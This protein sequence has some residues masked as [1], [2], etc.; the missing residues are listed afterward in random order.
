MQS[1][2]ELTQPRP[3]GGE[4]RCT[5]ADRRTVKVRR[6]IERSARGAEGGA[7]AGGEKLDRYSEEG[8][9]SWAVFTLQVLKPNSDLLPFF[10]YP[11]LTSALKSDR[12]LISLCTPAKTM[13]TTEAACTSR[14][15]LATNPEKINISWCQTMEVN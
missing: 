9:E 7:K 11:L 5:A 12:Y 15:D 2:R 13:L 10:F 8:E 1:S 6:G 3:G 4:Q 14:R